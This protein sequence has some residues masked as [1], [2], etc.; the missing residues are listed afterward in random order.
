MRKTWVALGITLGLVGCT[1]DQAPLPQVEEL[2]QGI[3]ILDADATRGVVAA[4]REV[5]DVIYLETRIGAL[6]PAIY[7]ESDP[8]DTANEVDMMIVDKH[9]MPF[10]VQRGGDAYVDPTWDTKIAIAKSTPLA[11]DQDRNHDFELAQKMGRLF[12]T[13]A[14]KSLSIST[15]HIAMMGRQPT[16]TQDPGLVAAALKI[17]NTPLPTA[18]AGDK[19]RWSGGGWWYPLGRL[20]EKC[21]ALC[22]GHHS[23]VSNWQQANGTNYFQ[24]VENYCNHGTC[25]GQMGWTCDKYSQWNYNPTVTGEG[26]TSTSVSTAGCATRYDWWG[27]SNTHLCNDD[28]A[29][30]LV[31]IKEGN[32]NT[33]MGGPSNFNWGNYSCNVGRGKWAVPGCGE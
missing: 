22:A 12:P 1:T 33:S 23:A 13:V 17:K 16:P 21:V 27:G 10:Y 4:Y 28:S 5:D 7:R 2:Q 29:Y 26:T 20:Y 30:E 8:D 18:G 32:V 31:Q 9:G 3:T 6:K 14:D 15:Y 11:A 24:I 25:A 19:A